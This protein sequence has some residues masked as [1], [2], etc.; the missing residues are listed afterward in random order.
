MQNPVFSLLLEKMGVEPMCIKYPAEPSTSLDFHNLLCPPEEDFIGHSRATYS[1]AIWNT[2]TRSSKLPSH[3]FMTRI[4]I[5][6]ARIGSRSYAVSKTGAKKLSAI[7][8]AI[9]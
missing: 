2:A 7:F 5:P 3:L 9:I 1:S 6:L 8:L 4:P